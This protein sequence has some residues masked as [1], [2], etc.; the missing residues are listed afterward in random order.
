MKIRLIKST[1]SKLQECLDGDY[2][3]ILFTTNASLG[4][5]ASDVIYFRINEESNINIKGNNFFTAEGYLYDA[6]GITSL[7]KYIPGS[8]ENQILNFKNKR[9]ITIKFFDKDQNSI[10]MN[11]W[12][13]LIQKI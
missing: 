9:N 4:S 6:L 12:Q 2:K 1:D 11:S 5:L 10:T 8:N 7:F 3:L 13:M